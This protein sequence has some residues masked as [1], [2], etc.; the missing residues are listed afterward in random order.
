MGDSYDDR[1]LEVPLR[2]RGFRLECGKRTRVIFKEVTSASLDN[3]DSVSYLSKKKL[4]V[5]RLGTSVTIIESDLR[6]SDFFG[7]VSSIV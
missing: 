1:Q 6:P 5:I 3:V 4:H 7:P 2:A